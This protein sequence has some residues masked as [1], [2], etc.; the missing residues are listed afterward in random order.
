MWSSSGRQKAGRILE[1]ITDN[2]AA[3][4]LPAESFAIIRS[5]GFGQVLRGVTFTPGTDTDGR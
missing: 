3:A 2:L 5:A 1:A 4:S